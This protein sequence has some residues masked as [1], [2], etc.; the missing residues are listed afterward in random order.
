MKKLPY[1]TAMMPCYLTIV[2]IYILLFVQIS[3]KKSLAFAKRT[4]E[5]KAAVAVR[6]HESD[7]L[8]QK[9]LARQ[10]QTWMKRRPEVTAASCEVSWLFMSMF[11]IDLDCGFEQ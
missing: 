6:S 4:T 3:S 10:Q 7:K 2:N 11:V 5:P 9:L 8:I 1:K